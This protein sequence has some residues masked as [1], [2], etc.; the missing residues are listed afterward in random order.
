MREVVDATVAA[1][2][3]AAS[4]TGAFAAVALLLAVVGVYGITA[5][6]VAR[7]RREIG[8][9]LALGASPAGIYRRVIRLALGPAG[10]GAGAGVLAAYAGS[11]LLAS[12]LAGLGEAGPLLLLALP[13]ALLLVVALASSLPA[14]RAARVDPLE[15][16]RD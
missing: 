5:Y 4:L 6:A 7:R 1:P 13:L 8:I 10:L 3:L 15:M 12:R 2:R 11:R 16:V 9:R 14:R